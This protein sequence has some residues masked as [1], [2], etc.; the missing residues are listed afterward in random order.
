MKMVEV[1]RVS[2][3]VL[4]FEEDTLRLICGYAP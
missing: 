1:R 3:R 4:A 2:G